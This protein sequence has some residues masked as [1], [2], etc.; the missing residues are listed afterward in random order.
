MQM[1]GLQQP[2]CT[3]QSHERLVQVS[4]LSKRVSKSTQCRDNV[5]VL[6]CGSAGSTAVCT[7]AHLRGRSGILQVTGRYAGPAWFRA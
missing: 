7:A 3:A 1:L 4:H 2:P 6:L 5:V